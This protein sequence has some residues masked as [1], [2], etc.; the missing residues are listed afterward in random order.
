MQRKNKLSQLM[1]ELFSFFCN[2]NIFSRR[3]SEQN[4]KPYIQ[5]QIK[6]IQAFCAFYAKSVKT[7][8]AYLLFS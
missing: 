6:I 3:Q 4:V 1:Y 8:V 2:E 5:E 7:W